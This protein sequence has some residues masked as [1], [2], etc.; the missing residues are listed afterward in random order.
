MKGPRDSPFL[1]VVSSNMRRRHRN[2]LGI[3]SRLKEYFSSDMP[4]LKQK[5]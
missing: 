5:V 1:V 4:Q 2:S 3:K